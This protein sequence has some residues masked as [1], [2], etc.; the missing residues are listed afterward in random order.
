MT[1]LWL[2]ILHHV[3][4]FGLAIMLAVQATLLRESMSADDTARIAR[5]DIGYGASAGLIVIVGI[6]RVIYGAKGYLYYVENVWFWAKMATFAAMGLLSIPP[7]LRFRAWQAARKANA[8][9]MPA[10]DEIRAL[11]VYLRWELRLLI[12]VVAF[13]ATMARYTSL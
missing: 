2:A 4:V 9:F 5:L 7:T 10:S 12:G 3:L 11:R 8:A 6:L 13:A 1:D